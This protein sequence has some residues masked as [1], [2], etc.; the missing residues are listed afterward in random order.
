[1][2]YFKKMVD[3]L[4]FQEFR[5]PFYKP[6]YYDK[7]ITGMSFFHNMLFIQKGDNNENSNV[8]NDNIDITL[9]VRLKHIKRKFISHVYDLFR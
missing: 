2:N 5:N 6:S 8:V 7:H 9:K 3:G 1:M 4:N